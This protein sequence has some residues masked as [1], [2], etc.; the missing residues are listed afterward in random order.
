MKKKK[1]TKCKV[2]K[3]ENEANF[4]KRSKDRVGYQ[5]ECRVCY[6]QRSRNKTG[7]QFEKMYIG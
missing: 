5:S 1:C 2:E 7:Y 3:E 4:Y 6:T